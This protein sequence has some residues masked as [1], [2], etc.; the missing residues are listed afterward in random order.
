MKCTAKEKKKASNLT[1]FPMSGVS[2]HLMTNLKECYDNVLAQSKSITELLVEGQ[3][4]DWKHFDISKFDSRL[5]S[6][7]AVL[8]TTSATKDIGNMIVC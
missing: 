8:N 5:N 7:S 4:V 6:I 3:A 1:K 2:T